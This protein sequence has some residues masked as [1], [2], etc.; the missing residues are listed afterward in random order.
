MM[1]E[2]VRELARNLLDGADLIEKAEGLGNAVKERLAALDIHDAAIAEKK[3]VLAELNK[4]AEELQ[5]K[6]NKAKDAF[7]EFEKSEKIRL[8]AELE[9][10]RQLHAKEHGEVVAVHQDLISGLQKTRESLSADVE[11]LAKTRD[12]LRAEVAQA[13]QRISALL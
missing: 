7:A 1:F 4:L 3:A 12:N 11:S 13:K 8:D 6:I 9:K 5:A 2:N 10:I